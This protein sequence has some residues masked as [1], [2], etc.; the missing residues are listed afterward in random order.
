MKKIALC[1]AAVSAFALAA[2]ASA[3][4]CF[5]ASGGRTNLSS[6][7]T[8]TTSCDKSGT[9]G[10][11]FGGYRFLPYLGAEVADLNFGKAK[12]VADIDGTQVNAQI[13]TSGF[14]AGVTLMGDLAPSWTATAPLGVAR[15]TADISGTAGGSAGSDKEHSTQAYF[16]LGVGYAMSKDVSLD[17]SA[18]F[19][20][21]NYAGESASVRMIAWA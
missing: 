12:A 4:G 13:K 5:G 9:G 10:K 15:M 7:C 20:R 18:D 19:S 8:G 2:P 17:A 16:G 3:Q 14:G 21:S 6:D 11:V 1:L